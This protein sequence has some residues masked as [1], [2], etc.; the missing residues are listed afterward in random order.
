[1]IAQATD[2]TKT[3]AKRGMIKKSWLKPRAAH[4][5]KNV[6]TQAMTIERIKRQAE[7]WFREFF[8]LIFSLKK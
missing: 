6:I 3:K 7:N 1:M 4:I 8:L 5:A 2:K